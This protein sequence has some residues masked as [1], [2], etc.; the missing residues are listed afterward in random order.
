MRRWGPAWV[1]WRSSDDYIGWAPLPP[2]ARWRASGG[3]VYSKAIYESPSFSI[4][5]N[6][7]RPAYITSPTLV[8]YYV[9]R[10]D[11]TRPVGFFGKLRQTYSKLKLLR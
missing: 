8:R 11:V 3:L 6:F 4:Y 1:A 5:W 2:E 7:S 9:P 10:R